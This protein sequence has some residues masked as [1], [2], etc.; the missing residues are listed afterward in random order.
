[1]TSDPKKL[2]KLREEVPIVTVHGYKG[3][4]LRKKDGSVV[5]I[6]AAQ[7]AG[8]SSPNLTLPSS[9]IDHDGVHKTQERDDITAT[10][11][12]KGITVVPYVYEPEIYGNWLKK[13]R[14]MGRHSYEFSYDWRR[15]NIESL[16]KLIAYLNWISA[17]HNGVKVQIVAH[18]MGGLLTMAALNLVPH[19]VHSVLFAGAPLRGGPGLIPD[20]HCGTIN[21][22]NKDILSPQVLWTF[23]S[24]Y[25]IS[26]AGPEEHP[27]DPT[28]TGL[29]DTDAKTPLPMDWFD[30]E[31]WKK[32]KFG[33]LHKYENDQIPENILTHV[34]NC[35]SDSKRLRSYILP[36]K[37]ISY[38]P[39][40]VMACGGT[41]TP[42][43]MIKDGPKSVNGWDPTTFCSD[44]DGRVPL[45]FTLPL[46]GLP[47]RY[48]EISGFSHEYLLNEV[49]IPSW[50]DDM[51]LVCAEQGTTFA[52]NFNAKL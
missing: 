48:F 10:H 38:P 22:L 19:L 7:A 28:Y 16:G 36:R 13:S 14:T 35:L 42:C 30:I 47:H 51:L 46:P 44:G 17:K 6:T 32:Y 11:T 26:H 24:I 50:L 31:Y 37:D 18:S 23:P 39:I 45:S 40:T 21:V 41:P 15:S 5:W 29:L 43:G 20:L 33:I 34:K 2:R 4:V 49:R 25:S 3:S 12:L 1:M 8:V 27:E 52:P 9:W